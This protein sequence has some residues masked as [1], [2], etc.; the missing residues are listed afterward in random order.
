[1]HPSSPDPEWEESRMYVHT[2]LK[3]LKQESH[4]I[5]Q[6][7]TEIHVQIGKLNRTASYW[8]AVAGTISTLIVGVI[9][10]VISGAL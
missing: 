8:G 2:T 5:R 1:M 3:D 4:Q 10:T 9:V 6:Q 7:L